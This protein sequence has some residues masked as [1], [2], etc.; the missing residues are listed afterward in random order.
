MYIEYTY[1]CTYIEVKFLPAN[2]T[3][4]LCLGRDSRDM[5]VAAGPRPWALDDLGSV[6]QKDVTSSIL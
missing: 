1:V 5:Q 6:L 3:S 2:I 4:G